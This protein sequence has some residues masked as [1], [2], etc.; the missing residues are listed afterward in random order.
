MLTIPLLV[1]SLLALEGG[2]VGDPP[3]A[4]T[5]KSPWRIAG[6]YYGDVITHPGGYVGFSWQAAEVRPFSFSVGADM[7]AYH[8]RRNHTGLFIR[9]NFASRVTFRPGVFIEPRFV[10]GYAHT[11]VDGDGYFVVDDEEMVRLS[12]PAGS[13]D[14]V[15]GFGFG[16][17][18]EIQRGRAAGLAFIVRPEVL[19][20]APY[21]DS[22]LTQFSLLVGMQWRFAVRSK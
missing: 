5:D 3:D 22:A 7:G 1:A 19:A 17:G 4:T 12:T 16:I 8:H 20:R 13:P 2:P 14:V 11:W 21:N 9:G 10:L 15:Y 6:G 18:Y